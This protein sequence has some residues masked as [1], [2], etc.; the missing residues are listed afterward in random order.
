[1][2]VVFL[3]SPEPSS[4]A[5]APYVDGFLFHFLFFVCVLFR[6]AFLHVVVIN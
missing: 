6:T 5:L 3:T 2:G 1:M 4:A